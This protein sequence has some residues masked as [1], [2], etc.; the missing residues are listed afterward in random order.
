MP[1]KEN[2][3]IDF[4]S[5]VPVD[6]IIPT[7]MEVLNDNE[8]EELT[9]DKVKE[10]LQKAYDDLTDEEKRELYIHQLKESKIR[11]RNTISKGNVTT[12][13]FGP[14]YRKKR[15]RKNK[16]AKA[17]RRLNRKK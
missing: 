8:P 6:E 10:M 4:K 15:Q 3:V 14:E 1:E 16:M 5:M 17:S 13:K 2:E 11:F 9:E 12:T 7:D